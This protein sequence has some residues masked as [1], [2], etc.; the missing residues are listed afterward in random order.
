L[1][2]RIIKAKGV[3]RRFQ[4]GLNKEESKKFLPAAIN[5]L[6]FCRVFGHARAPLVLTAIL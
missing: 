3:L 6:A 1:D 5:L 2:A 4:W